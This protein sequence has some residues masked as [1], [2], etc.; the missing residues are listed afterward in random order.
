MP[1]SGV[2]FDFAGEAL[3]FL[4]G[5]VVA[6]GQ[7]LDRDRAGRVQFAAAIHDAEAAATH[8]DWKSP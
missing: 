6:G 5:E 7:E 1:Q 2:G 3:A 4:V 8:A